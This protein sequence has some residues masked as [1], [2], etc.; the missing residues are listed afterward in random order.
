MQHMNAIKNALET[1]LRLNNMP[2]SGTAI[3]WEDLKTPVRLGDLLDAVR[4][5]TTEIQSIYDINGHVLDTQNHTF[6]KIP[7]TEKE[8]ALLV[9]LAQ[10]EGKIV[11]RKE[12]LK[13]VWEYA[14]HAETH[15]IETHIYRLRKK[16]EPDPKNPQIILTAQNGYRLNI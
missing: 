5:Q 9:L 14:E 12:I 16:I 4:A 10:Q 7:I 6:N 11:D 1:A 3:N 2:N 15:T 13:Q 8:T